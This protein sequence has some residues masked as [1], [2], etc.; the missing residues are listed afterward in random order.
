MNLTKNRLYVVKSNNVS[1]QKW[2]VEGYF[3]DLE[4]AKREAC[5][6]SRNNHKAIVIDMFTH[7]R[8]FECQDMFPFIHACE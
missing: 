2:N 3:E 6:V 5:I 1:Y 4:R 8:V 7:E